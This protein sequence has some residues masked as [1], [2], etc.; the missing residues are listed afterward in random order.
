MKAFDLAAHG[1]LFS[2]QTTGAPESLK[3]YV[4]RNA[5]QTI[6]LTLIRKKMDT[7]QP[8]VDIE[9]ALPANYDHVSIMA[10]TAP[11]M[12]LHSSGQARRSSP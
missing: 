7:T 2:P 12:E 4:T 10:L 5:N 9:L 6:Y 8:P 11:S 3:I 1:T